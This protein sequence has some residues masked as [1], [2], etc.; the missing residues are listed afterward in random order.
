[1]RSSTLSRAARGEGVRVTKQHL[2]APSRWETRALG[3]LE[4]RRSSGERLAGDAVVLEERRASNAPSGYGV[5]THD[6][7]RE[8]RE[9]ERDQGKDDEKDGQALGALERQ[10]CAEERRLL[11]LLKD[12]LEV[13]AEQL[14]DWRRGHLRPARLELAGHSQVQIRR[15]RRG[16]SRLHA[17]SARRRGVQNAC[18]SVVTVNYYSI[19]SLCG[20]RRGWAGVGLFM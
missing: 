1:M 8:E 12:E 4:R 11:E 3:R 18:I 14:V 7:T 10:R 2:A 6:Q 20:G 16:C 5:V 15:A 19:K 13:V 17:V 9:E